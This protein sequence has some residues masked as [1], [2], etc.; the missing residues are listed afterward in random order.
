MANLNLELPKLKL[1]DGTEIPMLGYGT[2][3]AMYKSV[4]DNKV[5][6]ERVKQI[7]T[8]LDVGYRHLDGAEMYNTEMELGVA[9]KESKIPRDQLFVTTKV[10]EG[11]NDIARAIDTSLKKLQLDYVD[12]YL[13]HTPFFAKSDQDLQNAWA[14]MEKVKASGKARSIG[15]SNYQQEHLEATLKTAKVPPSINQTEFHAYLQRE[16]LVPW[17][18]SKTIA[19]A[20][21]GPLV[22]VTKGTPGPLDNMLAS[23]A[24]KHAVNEGEIL[25]RW[26]IDQGVVA[27]TTSSKEQ[28]LSDMLRVATFKMTPREQEDLTK[29]GIEKHFRAFWTN[30]FA[31]NDR[32]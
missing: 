18:K 17:S 25:L 20:A 29:T 24:K 15:V 26:C 4:A 32:S 9:I 19:T 10:Q 30:K 21:Y 11:V 2:G 12:L 23:L 22:P 28:R 7:R 13:I 5:D 16:N 31:S 27:V 6:R 3:T 8:A 14:E 1:N